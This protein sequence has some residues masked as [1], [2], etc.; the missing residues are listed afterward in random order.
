MISMESTGKGQRN[1]IDGG[2]G[3]QDVTEEGLK[4]LGTS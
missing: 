2:G 1:S 3:F 4:A